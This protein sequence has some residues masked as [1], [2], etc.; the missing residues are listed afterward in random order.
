VDLGRY[1]KRRGRLETDRY[2]EAYSWRSL[3]LP[4]MREG[5]ET[6]LL[7]R[8]SC[9]DTTLERLKLDQAIKLTREAIREAERCMT[10]ARKLIDREK[11]QAR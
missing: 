1:E 2:E 4:A 5:Y 6:L 8:D 9:H 3:A 7:A 11:K 10:V